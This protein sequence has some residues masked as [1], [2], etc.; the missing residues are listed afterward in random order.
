MKLIFWRTK[1]FF[2]S[3]RAL[4]LK[5][6]H[7]HTKLPYQKLYVKRNKTV[8]AKWTYHKEWSFA[9]NYFIFGKLCFSLKTFCKELI[10]C[11]KNPIAHICTFC[12]GWSFI[13]RCSF[14]VCILKILDKSTPMKKKYMRANYATFMTKKSNY[15]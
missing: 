12:K 7:F 13:W 6:H 11:N 4:R 9:S 5:T 1:T 3:W 14:P 10:C 8:T 2:F 15:D